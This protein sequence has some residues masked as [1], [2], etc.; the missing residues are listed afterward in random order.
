MEQLEPVKP[1]EPPNASDAGAVCPKCGKDPM[2]I[3]NKQII[4]DAGMVF[5]LTTCKDCRV[6][7]GISVVAKINTGG[8]RIIRPS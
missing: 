4:D 2:E 8:G 1:P 6:F 5:L 3:W 7:V